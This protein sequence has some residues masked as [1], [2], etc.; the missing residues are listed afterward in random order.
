M[1][2]NLFFI[3]SIEIEKKGPR[4]V[5]LLI[6]LNRV[7]FPLF[8]L[9]M[10]FKTGCNYIIDKLLNILHLIVLLPQIFPFFSASM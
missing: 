7:R 4:D 3:S 1:S 9:Q 8:S 6:H 10:S 2:T 5:S